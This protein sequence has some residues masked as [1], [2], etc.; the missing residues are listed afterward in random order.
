MLCRGEGYGPPTGRVCKSFW[1]L[2]RKNSHQNKIHVN[3]HAQF[4]FWHVVWLVK[5]KNTPQLTLY[6]LKWHVRL[7]IWHWG[8][9]L[10]E[11]VDVNWH[12]FFVFEN[13]TWHFGFEVEHQMKFVKHTHCTRSL[14]VE[15]CL[16]SNKQWLGGLWKAMPDLHISRIEGGL[17]YKVSARFHHKKIQ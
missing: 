12:S 10:E 4:R 6:K 9:T 5:K 16:L 17:V 3:W 14:K 7:G 8:G 1:Y 11:N 15:G 2:T 13:V